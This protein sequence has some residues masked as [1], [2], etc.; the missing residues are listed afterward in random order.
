MH[1][2]QLAHELH[3]PW[4]EYWDFLDQFVDMS[5]TAGLDMLEAYF[6]KRVWLTFVNDFIENYG[7]NEQPTDFAGLTTPVNNRIREMSV[8]DID[9]S[10][11]SVLIN[12]GNSK[13]SPSNNGDGVGKKNRERKETDGL[14]ESGDTEDKQ[15][16]VSDVLSPVTNLL[17]CFEQ[18]KLQDDSWSDRATVDSSEESISNSD[19]S[20]SLKV[21]SSVADSNK[22]VEDFGVSESN[23]ISENDGME[24]DQLSKGNENGHEEVT[25][26]GIED[27]EHS[28]PLE[29]ADTKTSNVGTED[30]KIQRLVSVGSE[31]STSYVTASED[32][33][34]TSLSFFSQLSEEPGSFHVCLRL[35]DSGIMTKLTEYVKAH[36][37][38]QNID[39]DQVVVC[40][41]VQVTDFSTD[42][43]H[44]V[45]IVSIPEVAI[46]RKLSLF[47]D[48]DIASCDGDISKI[49][50]G[51]VMQLGTSCGREDE[52]QSVMAY[53]TRAVTLPKVKYIHGYKLLS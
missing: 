28:A 13:S 40:F 26:E 32:V 8:E 37:L 7:I 36:R 48:V 44:K 30:L 51:E 5:T 10:C 2:R 6:K 3:I 4:N 20:N 35:K 41:V 16:S 47:E 24:L 27:N 21:G 18:T 1:C 42:V 14:I 46:V 12:D 34:R 39:N 17:K 52:N 15:T 49:Q 31:S 53:L 9:R 22:L 33:Q 11:Y 19:S 43:G 23:V 29:E 45:N 50:E 25:D 38:C